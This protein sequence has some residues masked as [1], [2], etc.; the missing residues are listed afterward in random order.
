MTQY[1]PP[2]GAPGS[3][4]SLGELVARISENVTG[5]V[6]GEIELAKAKGKRMAIA[7]GLGAG[8]LAAAAVLA[9]YAL[10]MLLSALAWAI[11]EALSPW[12]GHLIVAVLLLVVVAVLAL[13]GVNRLKAA[14]ADVPAPQEGIKAD[15]ALAKA[16]LQEGLE[17]GSLK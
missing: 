1:Q 12:A 17:K 10:G 8:L 11:A 5:L 6:K 4:P 2:S 3:Q 16:A 15:V 14:Q 13:L 9:L 7:L